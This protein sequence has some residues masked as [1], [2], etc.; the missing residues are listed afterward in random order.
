MLAL[1]DRK[2]SV[3]T[4]RIHLTVHSPIYKAVLPDRVSHIFVKLQT[5]KL[6]PLE[7]TDDPTVVSLHFRKRH[8][9]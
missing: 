4:Q 5:D 7:L 9:L 6:V 3:D 8:Y 2:D 1:L